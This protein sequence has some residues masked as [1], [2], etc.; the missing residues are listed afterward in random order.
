MI[1]YEQRSCQ[2][3]EFILLKQQKELQK[4]SSLRNLCPF[5]DPDSNTLRVGVRL[6]NSEFNELKKFP[7]FIPKA[8][9][10]VSLII[11]HFHE[12]TLRGGGQLTHAAI[13]EQFWIVGVKPVINKF[14]QTCV[15]C[16]RYSLKP[17]F[18]LMAELPA[19]RVT[20]ARPFSLCGLDFAGHIL[21]K[22]PGSEC[23]KRFIA[24]YV[25]SR[26]QFILN[27]YQISLKKHAFWL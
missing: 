18:Q 22:L 25:S 24:L 7:L 27:S 2:A 26:R 5:F 12:E 13:R 23:Q 15:K 4:S 9:P 8:S 6:G 17:P 3:E 1:S 11:R 16:C 10:L 21:T 14:I 20:Q 19:E